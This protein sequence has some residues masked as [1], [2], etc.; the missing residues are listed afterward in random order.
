M[1]RHRR[2]LAGATLAAGLA[3]FVGV[4]PAHAETADERFARAVTSLGI[5]FGPETDLPAAGRQVCD[6]LSSGLDG[7][8]NPVPVV[9]GVIAT[10]ANSGMS[11][12]Q[13]IGLMQASVAIYCPQYTR[14]IGR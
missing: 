11:R 13:G 3:L 2:T 8:V 14:I 5:E 7:A 10:L 4:A 12:Q 9:R 6:M 1:N